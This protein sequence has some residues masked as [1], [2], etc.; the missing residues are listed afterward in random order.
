MLP[1]FTDDDEGNTRWVSP[2]VCIASGSETLNSA[3]KSQPFS[4][5]INTL[6]KP[7]VTFSKFCVRSL[8][9]QIKLY[10]PTPPTT[11]ILILPLVP[12]LQLTLF[13]VKLLI[14]IAAGSVSVILA[15]S[16]LP[17]KSVTTTLNLLILYLLTNY[18]YL[19]VLT[20]PE[21]LL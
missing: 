3:L 10:A 8:V 6:Y 2:T 20:H 7:L 12:L 21:H 4:S 5:V 9:L 18:P 11:S 16:L 19:I 15:D 13:I 14:A 17:L 1:S